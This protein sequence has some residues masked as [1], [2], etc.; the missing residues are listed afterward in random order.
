MLAIQLVN[1]AVIKLGFGKASD[2]FD[3]VKVI[4][5]DAKEI[6]VF[7]CDQVV[8]LLTDRLKLVN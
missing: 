6:A 3:L 2:G 8:T 5:L 4:Q 1:Q 7:Y